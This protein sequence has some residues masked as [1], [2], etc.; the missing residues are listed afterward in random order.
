MAG[1]GEELPTQIGSG[2]WQLARM[3][4]RLDGIWPNEG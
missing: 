1:G 2:G 4:I 3:I